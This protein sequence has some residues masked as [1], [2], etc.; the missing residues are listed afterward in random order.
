MCPGWVA[1]RGRTYREH[2]LVTRGRS[3]GFRFSE[4]LWDRFWPRS[5]MLCGIFWRLVWLLLCG[6]PSIA[7]SW[8]VLSP[9]LRHVLLAVSVC[10][11]CC[12]RKADV[13]CLTA[14]EARSLKSRCVRRAG[15]LAKLL[16]VPCR[17]STP[18][19]TGHCPSAGLS[20][21]LPLIRTPAVLDRGPSARMTLS[22]P[23]RQCPASM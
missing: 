23:V 16:V 6:V 9:S 12:H 1:K 4:K 21:C 3:F 7:P 5:D 18:V 10:W 13:Y 14:L 15:T 22:Q 11:S 20:K 19:L 2:F 8:P 17:S